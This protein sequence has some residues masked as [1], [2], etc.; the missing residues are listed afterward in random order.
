MLT[1]DAYQAIQL[2]T[3]SNAQ[4]TNVYYNPTQPLGTVWLWPNPNTASNQL[5]LYLQSQFAGFADLTTD[6]TY[7]DVAGY[8]E[9]LEYNLA[10]RL[11]APYGR[12]GTDL[13]DVVQM[14]RSS[15]ALVKR[16]NY[17]MTDVAIDPAL[18]QSRRG[19][20][21]LNTGQGG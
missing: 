15:L 21:N 17:R 6:Y 12:T 5:V 11:M 4:F 18:T 9:M 7:P 13:Q 19:G 2:K 16:Q 8:A 3:L 1:D 20:Y 10:V 14:A